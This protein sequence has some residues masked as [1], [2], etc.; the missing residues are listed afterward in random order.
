MKIEVDPQK[1]Y[2]DVKMN[3]LVEACG[4]I[5]VFVGEAFFQH[6]EEPTTREVFNAVMEAYGM[7]FGDGTEM[8]VS[9]TDEGTWVSS[10]DDDE[11]LYPLLRIHW[12]G[13][14]VFVY[15]HALVAIKGPRGRTLC[16][17]ID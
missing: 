13:L 17:R 7:G 1:K 2:T 16:T 14:E 6:P 8:E 10:Y 11:D 9:I 5:P 12:E 3:R 4:M 15:Q